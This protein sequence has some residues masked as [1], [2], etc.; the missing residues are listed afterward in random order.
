[1]ADLKITVAGFR[2]WALLG[3]AIAMDD[4]TIDLDQGDEGILN[5]EVSDEALETASDTRLT[6]PTI[7]GTYASCT[8]IPCGI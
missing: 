4:I 1:V 6:N 3:R 5:Q 7:V 2:V 8:Y